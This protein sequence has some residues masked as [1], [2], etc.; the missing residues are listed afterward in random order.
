M[1]GSVIKSSGYFTFLRRQTPATGFN[2]TYTGYSVG[3]FST[4]DKFLIS[5]SV[6]PDISQMDG[7]GSYEGVVALVWKKNVTGTFI[8]D[9]IVPTRLSSGISGFATQITD[10][11]AASTG[12]SD[13]RGNMQQVNSG[14]TFVNRAPINRSKVSNLPLSMSTDMIHRTAFSWKNKFMYVIHNGKMVDYKTLYT[15]GDNLT[16][17]HPYLTATVDW[18]IRAGSGATPVSPDQWRLIAISFD[19][20][21]GRSPKDLWEWDQQVKYTGNHQLSGAQYHWEAND[22]VS[23][24]TGSWTDRIAGLQMLKGGA[25]AIRSESMTYEDS[26]EWDPYTQYSGSIVFAYDIS[27]SGSYELDG[28]GNVQKVIDWSGFGNHYTGSNSASLPRIAGLEYSPGVVFD[29]V[30]DFLF[31]SGVNYNITSS[32]MSESW[33]MLSVHQL[34]SGTSTNFWWG[35]TDGTAARLHHELLNT[36]PAQR[37]YQRVRH[38]GSTSLSRLAQSVGPYA[39]PDSGSWG[40]AMLTQLRWD[41][42]TKTLSGSAQRF[43]VLSLIG[44][45]NTLVG[46][47]ASG[48]EMTIGNGGNQ[49]WGAYTSMSLGA[50]F[51]IKTTSSFDDY[52]NFQA[53]AARKGWI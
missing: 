19:G 31:V 48:S 5:A 44:N 24:G 12:S 22:W 37:S 27:K 8:R 21:S 32:H 9:F 23:T 1:V 34:I 45:E 49:Q 20:T 41:L 30:N 7:T 36:P 53:W 38:W 33:L 47:A 18:E 14:S 39:V 11:L 43:H 46:P 52:I 17:L 13:A 35:I 51:G 3:G 42:P 40:S 6:A 2:G 29:G 26:F 10:Q 25:P 4:A 15:G 50:Q 28:A 16:D